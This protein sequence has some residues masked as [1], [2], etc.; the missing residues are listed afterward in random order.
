MPYLKICAG[1][2]GKHERF[3][4]SGTFQIQNYIIMQKEENTVL[5]VLVTVA[6]DGDC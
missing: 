6:F 4:V 5:L 1:I 3:Q 2:R